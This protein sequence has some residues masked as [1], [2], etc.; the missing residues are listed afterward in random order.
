MKSV[1]C[2]VSLFAVAC[3]F[4]VERQSSCPMFCPMNYAPLCGS[5][6]KTYSNECELHVTNCLHK[7]NVVKVHQGSC[8]GSD[9]AQLLSVSR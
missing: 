1:I 9:L 7:V 4:N 8:D 3:C 5:D 6:G 2:L